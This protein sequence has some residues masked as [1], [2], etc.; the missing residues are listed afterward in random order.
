MLLV[1]CYP[2]IT[3]LLNCEL[4]NIL[5]LPI[6]NLQLHSLN[7]SMVITI[8]NGRARE[9]FLEIFQAHEEKTIVTLREV[10]CPFELR[11]PELTIVTPVAIPLVVAPW[12][13]DLEQLM[14]LEL[15]GVNQ[16]VDML[17]HQP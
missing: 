9:V 14:T 7:V 12:I 4:R 8:A 10:D 5:H 6:L 16:G 2:K 1:Y 17:T 13:S 3:L 15:V 11:C